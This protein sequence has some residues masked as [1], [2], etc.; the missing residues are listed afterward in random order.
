MVEP[1]AQ[2]ARLCQT[3][4]TAPAALAAALA[5]RMAE[6]RRGSIALVGTAAASHSLPFAATYSASKAGLSRYADA[7][8]LAVRDRGVTVTLVSPGFFTGEA[9]PSRPGEIAAGQVADKMI[10]AVLAGRAELV[11]PRRFVLLRWLDRLLP[12][13]LRDRVLLS[14]RL[15]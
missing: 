8:R 11:V 9:A 7:L 12:R 6:R 15:P 13:P 5:E 2:V 1:P 4:F 3:N 10:A 14:L